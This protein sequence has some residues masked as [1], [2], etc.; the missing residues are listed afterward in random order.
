MK[1]RTTVQMNMRLSKKLRKWIVREKKRKG[2]TVAELVEQM[3]EDYINT[4]SRG[5][6]TPWPLD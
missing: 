1:K 5:G 3:A 6:A 4:E 2:W